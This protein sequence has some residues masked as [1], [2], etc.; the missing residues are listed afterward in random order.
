MFLAKIFGKLLKYSYLY[1]VTLINGLI[2]KLGRNSKVRRFPLKSH[3]KVM[4]QSK[5]KEV[6]SNQFVGMYSTNKVNAVARAASNFINTHRNANWISSYSK[7]DV[8]DACLQMYS[9]EKD[10]LKYLELNKQIWI[11]K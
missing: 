10:L 5:V 6:I 7:A 4:T 1:T 3:K 9:V 11:K 2:Y 8:I